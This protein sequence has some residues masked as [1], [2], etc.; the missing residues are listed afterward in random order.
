MHDAPGDRRAVHVH[1]EHRHEDAHLLRQ[2]GP[3]FT[4]GDVLDLHDGAVGGREDVHV[5]LGAGA[6]RIAEKVEQQQCE[7]AKDDRRC[8]PVEKNRRGGGDHRR[9]DEQP[10]FFGE[11]DGHGRILCKK[12]AEAEC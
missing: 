3:H 11:A 6:M 1:V 7:K 4:V 12:N 9:D 2:A 8:P 5:P 10:A